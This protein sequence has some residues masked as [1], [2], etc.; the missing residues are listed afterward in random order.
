MKLN[1]KMNYENIKDLFID[2]SH[3]G[4][5]LFE[6]FGFSS[7]EYLKGYDRAIKFNKIFKLKTIRKTRNLFPIHY[8][9][10]IG[11]GGYFEELDIRLNKQNQQ[12][13]IEEIIQEFMT[14]HTEFIRKINPL[15]EKEMFIPYGV[16]HF[17]DGDYFFK[18]E[19]YEEYKYSIN[20]K[21]SGVEILSNVPD[22]F[23]VGGGING[24]DENN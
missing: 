10:I 22:K 20:T 5:G 17:N 1:K 7:Y 24:K 9:F 3:H 14:W 11:Q 18:K 21:G 8:S 19:E 12:G 23:K 6:E 16:I 4:I 13:V 2:S 15:C